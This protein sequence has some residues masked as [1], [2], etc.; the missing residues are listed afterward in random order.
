MNG[1]FGSTADV[2][3]LLA[4]GDKVGEE[5]IGEDWDRTGWVGGHH[6]NGG[7]G[8]LGEVEWAVNEGVDGDIVGTPAV[9]VIGQFVVAVLLLV[10]GIERLLGG[11]VSESS[12]AGGWIAEKDGSL[13]EENEGQEPWHLFL[14]L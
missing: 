11:E 13:V 7:I 5:D 3:D 8:G 14:C 2:L 6:D 4:T 9:M 1:S 10:V 12:V